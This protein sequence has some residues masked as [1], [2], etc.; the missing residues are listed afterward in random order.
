MLEVDSDV[1]ME[2]EEMSEEDTLMVD[3]GRSR[4]GLAN[5]DK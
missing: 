5:S 2:T 3:T 1:R 4:P